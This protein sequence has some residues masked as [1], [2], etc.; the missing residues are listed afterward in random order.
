VGRHQPED[1][2]GTLESS[3]DDRRVV[4]RPLHDVH[5]VPQVRVE[6]R[7][8][9]DDHPDELTAVEHAGQQLAADAAGGRGEDDHEQAPRMSWAG[10]EW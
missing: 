4:V 3:I 7:R 1:G 6:A 9:T 2:V 10:Q 8:V 5:P